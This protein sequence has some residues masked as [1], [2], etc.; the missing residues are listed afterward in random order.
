MSTL[1]EHILKFREAIFS[2]CQNESSVSSLDAYA[3]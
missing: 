3:T 2:V 1:E